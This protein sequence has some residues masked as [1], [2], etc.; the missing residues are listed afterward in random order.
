MDIKC[1]GTSLYIE[2]EFHKLIETEVRSDSREKLRERIFCY[3]YATLS[4]D[5]SLSVE[6][7]SCCFG[8]VT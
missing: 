3:L 4:V 2:L 5:I 8:S 1:K 7:Y 6:K